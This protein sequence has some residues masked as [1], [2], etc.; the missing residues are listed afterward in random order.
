M[1]LVVAWE[2]ILLFSLGLAGWGLFSLLRLPV[3]PFLGT[4]TVLTV[5]RAFGADIPFSPYWLFPFL[6]VLFGIYIGSMI[7]RKTLRDLKTMMLPAAI[8]ILWAQSVVFLMGPLLAWLTDI[9]LFTAFLSFCMAGP[10]EMSIIAIDVGADVGFIIIVHMIRIIITLF[11]FPFILSKWMS[12]QDNNLKLSE[13][14]LDS[15]TNLRSK[16]NMS[17]KDNHLDRYKEGTYSFIHS[18]Q[19]FFTLKKEKISCDPFWRKRDRGSHK[20]LR[21]IGW[22]ILIFLIASGGGSILYILGV[23]AGIMVGALFATALISLRWGETI[24]IPSNIFNIMLVG[25]G[26]SVADSILP[27]S[28]V[29]LTNPRLLTYIAIAISVI[30]ASSF[31]MA[32]L[33][34]RVSGKDLPTSFL[35]TAPAG[36]ITILVLAV[37]HDKDPIF[38]SMMLLCRVLSIKVIIPLVFTFFV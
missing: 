11:A 9:D 30:F 7:T 1:N 31:L 26:I 23:P 28:F 12:K 21:A 27:E 13:K 14:A 2:T 33:I 17:L 4:I 6:Q 16:K 34:H 25:V 20:K 35:S 22:V 24:A 10:A 8:I 18:F 32:L 29:A 15:D 19:K 3:A 38:V 36:L 5:L 37:E